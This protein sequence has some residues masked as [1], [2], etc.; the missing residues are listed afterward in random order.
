[1]RT[2]KPPRR[3][4]RLRRLAALAG[5]VWL[6][7]SVSAGAEEVINSFVS[8]IRIKADGTMN[9]L[10]AITVTAEG[11]KIRRGIYRDFPTDYRDRY[12]N[13]YHVRFDVLR[14]MRDGHPEPY[15]TEA[16]ANG[17]RVYIGSADRFVAPGRHTYEIIYSTDR[18]LGFFDQHDELYWN[19]TGND[20][21][22]VIEHAEATVTLPG[23]APEDEL[24]AEGYTGPRGSKARNLRATVSGPS[25]AHFETTRALGPH[26]GLTIVFAWP[27]GIVHEPT[28]LERIAATLRD[29]DHL[30]AALVGFLA[31]L[32]YYLKV[33]SRVGRDPEAG[34]IIARYEPPAGYSPASM[35]YIAEMGYDK[36]CFT[37]AI[38][39]L[40]VKGYLTIEDDDGDYTLRKTA[41]EVD[42]APGEKRLVD[43]LFGSRDSIRMT[44]TNHKIVKDALDQHE[45]ALSSDYENKYFVLNRIHF[46]G[47]IALTIVVAIAYLIFAPRDFD[48]A[49]AG[50]LTVW[51]VVWWSFTGVG[52]YRAWMQLRHT[53]GLGSRA[54]AVFRIL[55]LVPF[56]FA[57]LLVLVPLSQQ[58][59]ASVLVVGAVLIVTNLV[60]YH[61]L[62]AP[63][64][65]GRELM[66]KVEG[67]KH[68]VDVAEKLE[69]E[70][71]YPEGRTPAVFERYLPFAVALGIEQKWA[72]QFASVI[73]EAAYGQEKYAPAWYQGSHWRADNLTDFSSSLS[74]AFSGAVASSAIAPGSSSGLG[75]FS[76]GGGGGGS[77]GG[78]GGGGGGG[79]W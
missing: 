68:Y 77:S 63:T 50:F 73:S 69:L 30:V 9:V 26:E 10:E 42:M 64:L 18:Q 59:G 76:G 20:W 29:N 78:G 72:E 79:G 62:K 41:T 43:A 48:M 15:H 37:A 58:G 54:G 12:G 55:F 67:F 22:F 71:R 6:V 27:K 28:V 49:T 61:L 60:F 32:V 34:V 13:A 4:A 53:H 39:N 8:D 7:F 74:N 47:G 51:A 5:F 33:W 16:T 75:G 17:T 23:A 19:V 36:K 46:F 38:L 40:A 2:T 52:M 35:R 3:N 31:L 70:A 21:D 44:D 65:L 56:V 45:Q 24:V 11:T 57:G 25:S 66:D 14:V 1:M